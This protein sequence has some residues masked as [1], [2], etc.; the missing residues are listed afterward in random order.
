[1]EFLGTQTPVIEATED[2]EVFS[3][4]LKEINET[5]ALNYPTK[6]IKETK[7]AANKKVFALVIDTSFALGGLGSGIAQD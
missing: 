2:R 7:E 6:N 4:I 5:I 3:E 1:M